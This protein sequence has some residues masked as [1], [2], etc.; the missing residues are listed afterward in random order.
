M[1][2]ILANTFSMAVYHY[3]ISQTTLR[4]LD[5]AN[6]FFT[7]CFVV[8]MILKLFGLGFKSYVRDN[9]NL[10]D[11]AVIIIGLLEYTGLDTKGALVFRSFRL[12]RIFKIARQWSSLKKLLLLVLGSMKSIANLAFLLLLFMFIYTLIGMQFLSGPT[13]VPYDPDDKANM[14]AQNFNSFPNAAILVFILVTAEGWNS[15]VA[16]WIYSNGWGTSI[17]FIT[18]I[19]IGNTMILN[20]FLAILLN[21][22]SDNLEDDEEEVKP[23]VIEPVAGPPPEIIEEELDYIQE[24]LRILAKVSKKPDLSS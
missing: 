24:K 10:F 22:I 2:L 4:G 7:V 1:V 16:Q 18:I 12:L 5:V 3:G 11:T 8:E 17:Y 20:L 23:K 6:L 14:V 21:F 13:P 19:A 15:V 9:F